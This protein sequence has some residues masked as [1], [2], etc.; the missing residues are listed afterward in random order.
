MEVNQRIH[1]IRTLQSEIIKREDQILLALKKDLG[2]CEFEGVV[3][4]VQYVLSE[5]EHT[6]NKVRKWARPKRVSTP[7]VHWPAKSFIQYEPFGEVLI[8]G[9]WNYPFQLIISPLV[10]AISAGNTVTV[11]PSEISSH[12]TE[13]LQEILEHEILKPFITVE[14]GGVEETTNLLKRRFD[15]I[16]YTGSTPVGKIVMEAAA[17]HLTPVT[18]ELGGKSPTVVTKNANIEIAARRILWGKIMNAGQ[19]CIAPDYVLVD[20]EVRDQFLEKVQQEMK[21][22]LGKNPKDS[23][24]YGRIISDRHFERLQRLIPEN[25]II[26]GETSAEDKYIAPTVFMANDKDPIMQDEIFGPLLPILTFKETKEA[27]KKILEKE[28][29]LAFYLFSENQ[30]EIDYFKDNISSGGMCVNDTLIHIANGNLPFGGVGH[31]GMGAYH[32]KFSFET[33][34]HKKSIVIR[35]SFL[36]VK[37][38]Y[39]PYFGKLK[40]IRWLLKFIG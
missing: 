35:K 2:K 16:F 12:T 6:L 20:E 4:E 1:L 21:S 14:T 32:G 36:D 19:T 24:D 15:Y 23:P 10:G 31:S 34:S 11:K 40:I 7:L 22:L 25:I 28:K 38:K 3:T 39:P 8:I 5:I 26:G 37:L 13:V 9:P 17:K 18:L 30:S 29:P 27:T 33:F